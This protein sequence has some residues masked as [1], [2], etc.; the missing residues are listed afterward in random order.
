MTNNYWISRRNM[1]R[2]P[3][4][5]NGEG[6]GEIVEANLTKIDTEKASVIYR[7]EYTFTEAP[8]EVPTE[9]EEDPT[10]APTDAPATEAPTETDAPKGGCKSSVM[11]AA[12]VM[13]AMAA[14]VALR[15]KEN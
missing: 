7:K 4:G 15:K 12:A 11:G 3:F 6:W 10:E 5:E 14:A 2:L 9:P 1:P 13:A 8:T